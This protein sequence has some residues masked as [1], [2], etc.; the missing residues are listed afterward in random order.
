MEEEL[1]QEFDSIFEGDEAANMVLKLTSSS[2][3]RSV[4]SIRI[5]DIGYTHP[6]KT[7][8]QDT[9]SGLTSTVKDLGVVTPIHVMLTEDGAMIENG[10]L[11]ADDEDV[12]YKYILLDG[13]RRLYGAVRNG[14]K[15]VDAVIWNFEDKDKGTDY[16]T[17]IS[18]ILN[19]VQKRTWKEIWELYKILEM[20]HSLTPGVLEYLLQLEGG[21]AMKLKDVM[22]CEYDEV[23]EAL[24][25]GAKNLDGA[26]KMLQKLR[27]EENQLEKDDVMGITDVAEGAE[28]IA[29][30]N[31][32]EGQLTDEDVRELLDMSNSLND[33]DE[34]TDSDFDSMNEQDESFVNQQKVGERTP[35]PKELRDAVLQRD[36]FHCQCCDMH[37][38]GA[39]AGLSAV[40]HVLPVH[41]G[42]KD[43]MENLTT[44]CLNCHITLHNCERNGG[45]I[46]MSKEA[47]DELPDS[48]KLSLRKALKLARIAL[49]ADKRKGLNKEAVLKATQDSIRHP[50]PG[51]NLKEVQQAYKEYKRNKSEDGE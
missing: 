41:V 10:E 6:I 35:L 3:K 29:G 11:D 14:Q 27:K 17:V 39:R 8:R 22:L 1:Q 13:L 7:G 45:S 19:R 24:M 31:A 20:Q 18:M 26:Y 21:D 12:G 30:N 40:H 15:E 51:Q 34:V 4:K 36:D 2:F 43:K 46:M 38:I 37:L 28:E 33:L 42:G 32:E 50:M 47:F 48:E 44:L 5:E 25:S 9:V 16:A 23:K 49:E